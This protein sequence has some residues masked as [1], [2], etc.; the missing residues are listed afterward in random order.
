MGIGD[1]I[2]FVSCMAGTVVALPA[3]LM[4]LSLFFNRTTGAA[5]ARLNHGAILP[6]FAGLVPVIFIGVPS[7]LMFSIGSVTQFCGT[8]AYFALFLWAFTGLA[9][10]SRML[11]SSLGFSENPLA[12][13]AG[14]AFILTLAIFF[15]ILGWIV[16]LPFAMILGLG[17]TLLAWINRFWGMQRTA[18][19]PTLQPES[20]AAL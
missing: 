19:A 6:F 3:F 7:T 18:F 5:A 14:G 1:S 16:V 13:T 10:V 2:T 9:A 17:A 8:I 4:L 11:G 12:Q 15:P 20:S